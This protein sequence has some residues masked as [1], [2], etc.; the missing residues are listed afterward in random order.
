LSPREHW[1]SPEPG[2]I[3]ANADGALHY[4]DG[5]GGSGVVLRDHHGDFV[6]GETN[7]FSHV[8]DA[9]AAELLA[10]RRGILMSRE[11]QVQKLVLET[12][13]TG[14][15][16]K[17]VRADRDRSLNG[18]LVEEIKALLK[19][20][21]DHRVQAV[22]RFANEAAHLLAKLECDNKLCNVWNRVAPFEILDQLVMDVS[23]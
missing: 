18:V 5:N 1:L 17:L 6:S 15:A 11:N 16:A 23:V 20:F 12:D 8:A 4:V 19:E 13:S 10:C 9:E 21:S 14:V 7:F 22:R 2:W 3:K